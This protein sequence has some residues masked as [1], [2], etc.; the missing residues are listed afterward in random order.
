MP[1]V[2]M[3]YLICQLPLVNIHHSNYAH[4]AERTVSCIR[5]NIK[6][7]KVERHQP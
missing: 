1:D 3:I 4:T 6:M 2:N 7:Y 5:N